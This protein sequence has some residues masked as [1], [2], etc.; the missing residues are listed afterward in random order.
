MCDPGLHKGKAYAAT[1]PSTRHL[2]EKIAQEFSVASDIYS[3]EKGVFSDPISPSPWVLEMNEHHLSEG[4]L[5]RGYG[6]YAVVG[7]CV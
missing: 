6:L 2:G 3:H 7:P 4:A 5:S 1:H